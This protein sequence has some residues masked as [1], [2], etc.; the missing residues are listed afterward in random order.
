MLEV[1]PTSQRSDKTA[2]LPENQSRRRF[3]RLY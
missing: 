3:N 2:S 1:K